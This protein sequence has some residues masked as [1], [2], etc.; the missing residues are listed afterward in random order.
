MGIVGVAIK[1]VDGKTQSV[2]I[3][4]GKSASIEFQNTLIMKDLQIHKTSYDNMVEGMK[5]QLQV[6]ILLESKSSKKPI[7]TAI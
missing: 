3:E 6:M 4:S 5:F 1:T 7:R 2:D